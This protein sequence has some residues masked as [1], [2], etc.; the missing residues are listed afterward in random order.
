MPVCKS[1]AVLPCSRSSLHERFEQF[2]SHLVVKVKEN[3]CHLVLAI[4][5]FK[6]QGRTLPKLTLSTY[7]R[8]T[9]PG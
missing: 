4:T 2:G 8:P 1:L 7:K 5:D 9:P 3:T 6:L